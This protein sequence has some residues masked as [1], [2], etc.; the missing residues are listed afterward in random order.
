MK[1]RIKEIILENVP[2]CTAY[3]FGDDGEHFAALVISPV[4][5]DLPLIKQHKMVMNALKEEFA[6][7]VH[8]LQLKTFSPEKWDAAKH[9]Y[10][11][12]EEN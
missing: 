7:R 5:T 10:D 2:D 4:F 6:E 8:A 9:E 12:P 11:L 3:V 1:D